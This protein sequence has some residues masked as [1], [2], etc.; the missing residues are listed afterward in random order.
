MSNILISGTSQGLGLATALALQNEHNVT[1][2]ARKPISKEFTSQ[3]SFTHFE[4]VD[5]LDFQN[6]IDVMESVRKSDV[7]INN[8]GVG[9]DGLLA[10]Q[11]IDTIDRV[12]SV[13]LTSALHLTKS[14]VR[15]CLRQRK[16]GVV[17]NVSSIIAIRGYAGLAAYSASK[18]GLDGMT[19]SL[20]REMGSKGIR[21][22]SILP[23]YFDS[24]L[25]SSLNE[26]QRNQI[27]RRTP[28]GRLA[29]F[30]DV[31]PVIKFLISEDSKFITGQSLVVD[32]GITV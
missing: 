27:I 24:E 22:N 11:A 13:N 5:I 4:N 7:L 14:F 28:L 16:T 15:E 10:T 8:V 25:S 21:I 31:L 9:F 20:A 23:G 32:G 30:S 18:A 19:R 12:I 3:A 6:S 2:F 26:S 29:D 17:L 1:G